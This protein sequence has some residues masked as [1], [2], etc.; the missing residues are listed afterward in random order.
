MSNEH[1]VHQNQIGI[2][3]EIQGKDPYEFVVSHI[4]MCNFKTAELE[5]W[6]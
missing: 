5:F 6:N 3:F 1:Y 2:H 4:N